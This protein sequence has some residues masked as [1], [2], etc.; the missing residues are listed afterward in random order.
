[1]R[2]GTDGERELVMARWR[3]PGRPQYR[4]VPVTNVRNAAR[5][6]EVGLAR[7]L[8]VPATSFCDYEGTKPRRRQRGFALAEDRRLCAF[9]GLKAASAALR[10]CQEST[11][12]AAFWRGLIV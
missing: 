4:G 3:M 6:G 7:A 10:A 5:I 1:V 9:A 2:A 12:S 11:A 8:A